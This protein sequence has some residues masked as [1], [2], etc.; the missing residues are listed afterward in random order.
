MNLNDQRVKDVLV[1]LGIQ[2]DDLLHEL[3]RTA[4]RSD[5]GTRPS[6]DWLTWESHRRL[7]FLKG[8]FDPKEPFPLGKAFVRENGIV[9]NRH[10]AAV[11]QLVDGKI[12]LLEGAFE[13]GR[14]VVV[15]EYLYECTDT[16][17][18]LHELRLHYY[19]SMANLRSQIVKQVDSAT[20][21]QLLAIAGILGLK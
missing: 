8:S 13:E 2:I 9:V 16:G 5:D 17:N 7:T 19:G 20:A 10:R 6:T 4:A 15:A 21:G 12:S 14:I 18:L 11:A 1:G 3:R